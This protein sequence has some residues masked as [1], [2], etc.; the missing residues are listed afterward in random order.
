[1]KLLYSMLLLCGVQMLASTS[2]HAC[3]IC[4]CAAGSTQTGLLALTQ[5]H[6]VGAR[7]YSQAYRSRPHGSGYGALEHFQTA[8]LWGRWQ[9]NRR[10]Q[11]SGIVPL[12]Y[13]QRTIDDGTHQNINGLGDASLWGH[14]SVLP[15]SKSTVWQHYLLVGAG[16]SLPTGA[17]NRTSAEGEAFHA[18]VQPG[19][20]N[21]HALF[22]ALYLFKYRS[23]G[24]L[25]EGA[26]QRLAVGLNDYEFGNRTT[27]SARVFW[28]KSIKNT[29]WVPHLSA[30]HEKA[31]KDY[32]GSSY[33]SESGGEAWFAGAGLDVFVGKMT[34]SAS[35]QIP[36]HSALAKGF[37]TPRPRLQVGVAYALGRTRKMQPVTIPTPIPTQDFAH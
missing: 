7:W 34:L 31:R 8:E 29:V 1:M 35:T 27:R 10:L 12:R 9:I 17:T 3:D 13:N 6:I 32:D 16:A 18:N 14:V 20:G 28:T 30:Q 22:S 19:T 11:L 36:V 25:L 4:G 24:V 23:V 21:V 5:K 26:H 2:V 15:F 33:L 37:V